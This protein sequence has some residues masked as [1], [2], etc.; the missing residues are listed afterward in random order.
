WEKDQYGQDMK[1]VDVLPQSNFVQYSQ[2][3]TNRNQETWDWAIDRGDRKGIVITFHLWPSD[4]RPVWFPTMSPA[5]VV[6]YLEKL[7]STAWPYGLVVAAA[8]A[9]KIACR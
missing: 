3:D 4:V 1:D 2:V 8:C 5:D 6:A 9:A 7:P